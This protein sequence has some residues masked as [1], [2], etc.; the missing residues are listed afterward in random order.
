MAAIQQMA[1]GSTPRPDNENQHPTFEKINVETIALIVFDCTSSQI[2]KFLG[3]DVYSVCCSSIEKIIAIYLKVVI[4]CEDKE[5]QQ[6]Q[7]ASFN[8]LLKCQ[9]LFFFPLHESIRNWYTR[10]GNAGLNNVK[11]VLTLY[12]DDVKPLHKV[13]HHE[14]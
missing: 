13:M 9:N 5:Q 8:A 2:L 14:K 3:F 4:I 7:L 11:A 6:A 12:L 1:V 10:V